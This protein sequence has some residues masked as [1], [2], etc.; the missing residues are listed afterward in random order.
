M[1]NRAKEGENIPEDVIDRYKSDIAVLESKCAAL[2]ADDE[3]DESMDDDT[4]VE[5]DDDVSAESTDTPT[6]IKQKIE[7]DFGKHA[8][9]K[10]VF[11]Y[12]GA[13][14]EQA[15]ES[16]A[17]SADGT[18]ARIQ[19]ACSVAIND[20]IK[21]K[22][23]NA[24]VVAV[25]NV[26]ESAREN[27]EPL[28][29][30]TVIVSDESAIGIIQKKP[31]QKP[32]VVSKEVKDLPVLPVEILMEMVATAKTKREIRLIASLAFAMAKRSRCYANVTKLAD[33]KLC[34]L[35]GVR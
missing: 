25:N 30:K 17:E 3:S 12:V 4:N 20:A 35:Y 8:A 23:Q 26:I 2:P 13:T 1:Q 22:N 14:S 28:Q 33:Q 32:P 21:S 5:P 29:P 27:V 9:S 16:A 11:A 19:A 6:G 31:A 24:L 7:S 15:A 10:V 18:E 34:E